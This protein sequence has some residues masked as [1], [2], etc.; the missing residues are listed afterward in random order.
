MPM[1]RTSYCLVLTLS[2]L[3]T[4]SRPLPAEEETDYYED[5]VEL[6]KVVRLIKE[7]YVDEVQLHD[8]LTGAYRGM[9]Q[10]LD[11]YSQF[12]SPDEMED[13]R[14]ET[15]GEF[16]GMGI[17]VIMKDGILTVITPILDSPAFKA[18]ILPGDKI[19]RIEDE[20]AE[21]ISFREAIKRLRGAPGTK[22]TISVL[23]PDE[24][25][26]TDIT[27]ERDVVQLKSVIG[28]RIV[29]EEDKIG[30]VAVSTFQE[31]TTE[32]LENAVTAL[33]QEGMES[34]ILDLRFNPGGLLN[35]AVDVSDKFLE[36]DVIVSTKGKDPSQNHVYLAK[37]SGTFPNFPVIVLINNGSASAAEI[38]AGAIRDRKRGLLVGTKTFGKGSVQSLVPVEDE[39]SAIK[40]T[41]AKYY[42]PSGASIHDIGIEPDVVVELS[43]EETRD[44]HESIIKL[45]NTSLSRRDSGEEASPLEEV[46][47]DI[48][49]Q[50]ALD[51]L[52]NDQQLFTKLLNNPTL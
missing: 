32:D 10:E 30:Y 4:L 2:L 31:N 22:V 41:T 27:I 13:L 29:D 1:L 42:T 50:R 17:E 25:E 19:L 20:P 11:P 52:K 35:V 47:S 12:I 48:Q 45:K 46:P 44:L 40:L 51:I 34:L 43:K 28:S 16:G 26:T 38:V 21:N 23:H 5:Y 39:G 24:T 36:D 33:L 37:K 6:I 8:L 14:I 49:L 9:L 18:G 3:I 7:K 15:E